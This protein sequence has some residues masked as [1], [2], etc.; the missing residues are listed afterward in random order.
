[1]RPSS[2]RSRPASARCPASPTL[3]AA[4]AP[5][6]VA[7]VKALQAEVVKAEVAQ[8]EVVS[9]VWPP[10]PAV[11]W[12][13]EAS[14]GAIEIPRPKDPRFRGPL[15]RGL[16]WQAQ[17]ASAKEQLR[18]D[19]I[20]SVIDVFVRGMDGVAERRE[21]LCSPLG[22]P[23]GTPGDKRLNRELR[24]AAM[25]KAAAAVRHAGRCKGLSE[26][27]DLCNVYA[28]NWDPKHRAAVASGDRQIFYRHAGECVRMIRIAASYPNSPR[29]CEPTRM[30]A[31]PA[32]RAAHLGASEA[33]PALH[34]A[35]QAPAA[36]PPRR[37]G[38]RPVSARVRQ[39]PAAVAAKAATARAARPV[40]R[41]GEGA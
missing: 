18:H 20:L 21:L 38:A 16:G 7:A 2:A 22:V 9:E 11:P 13:L 41:A 23:Y 19:P 8:E 31:A 37:S 40:L 26:F 33:A 35:Q 30:A 4:A 29:P 28:S 14:D 6:A 34:A 25:V 5:G 36:P 17:A 10:V 3:A 32:P 24:D 12:A 1:M 15:E 27:H 39:P